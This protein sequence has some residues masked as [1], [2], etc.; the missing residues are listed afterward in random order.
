MLT[1]KS[2]TLCQLWLNVSDTRGRPAD[3]V[4]DSGTVV[5]ANTIR[6]WAQNLSMAKDSKISANGLGLAVGAAP[7]LGYSAGGS[8]GGSGGAGRC[9]LEA[10]LPGD[11]VPTL[12]CCPGS[13]YTLTN[14]SSLGAGWSSPDF[15]DESWSEAFGSGGFS[16]SSSTGGISGGRVRLQLTGNLNVDGYIEADGDVPSGD[17]AGSGSGGTVVIEA[18]RVAPGPE[19]LG[20]ISADGGRAMEDGG[21]PNAGMG[22]GGGGRVI[23]RYSELLAFPLVYSFITA[24]GGGF[25]SSLSTPVCWVG[26]AGTIFLQ[27]R[28]PTWVDG[29]P[30]YQ[31]IHIANNEWMGLSVTPLSLVWAPPEEMDFV[32]AFLVPS[33]L[34]VP[35]LADAASRTEIRDAA[36]GVDYLRI[37]GK[38]IVASEKLSLRTLFSTDFAYTTEQAMSRVGGSTGRGIPTQA[39]VGIV[40][41]AASLLPLA[42]EYSAADTA[43]AAGGRNDSDFTVPVFFP[44]LTIIAGS[45]EVSGQLSQLNS[46]GVPLLAAVGN[47]SLEGSIL[48]NSVFALSANGTI[49]MIAEASILSNSIS[50]DPPADVEAAK[51]A[52]MLALRSTGDIDVA[53]FV[54]IIV[55]VLHLHSE[56]SV[57]VE[58]TITV[59]STISREPCSGAI[60][61]KRPLCTSI[62]WSDASAPL[63]PLHNWTAVIGT[64]MRPMLGNSDPLVSISGVVTVGS[65][66]YAAGSGLLCGYTVNFDSN[67]GSSGASVRAIG[68]PMGTGWGA[69][70]DDRKPAFTGSGGSHG[71]PGGATNYSNSPLT[72]DSA[73]PPRAPG[74]GGG[75]STPDEKYGGDGGGLIVV[76]ANDAV[77][78]L[79][80]SSLDA[81]GGNGNMNGG[82]GGAAGAVVLRTEMLSG[83]GNIF[84]SGGQ[85]FRGSGGGGGGLF[86]INT[87]GVYERA[88]RAEPPLALHSIKAALERRAPMAE[89]C[90][91]AKSAALRDLLSTS[92]DTVFYNSS[93]HLALKGRENESDIDDMNALFIL[94]VLSVRSCDDA[95][96]TGGTERDQSTQAR[97]LG[98][99]QNTADPSS[100]FSG[101][102]DVSGG[103]GDGGG[104]PGGRG[105]IAAPLCRAG[106]VLV[107][108]R[109]SCHACA[110][111]TWRNASGPTTC[112]RCT[113]A[114]ALAEYEAP[115]DDVGDV[116]S[117][118]SYRCPQGLRPPGCLTP[119]EEL[120]ISFGGTSAFAGAI[121]ALLLVVGGGGVIIFRRRLKA[122]RAWAAASDAVFDK[123][124]GGAR[125]YGAAPTASA[126]FGDSQSRLFVASLEML[127]GRMKST[128]PSA[129]SDDFNFISYVGLSQSSQSFLWGQGKGGWTSVASPDGALAPAGLLSHAESLGRRK[130]AV[131]FLRTSCTLSSGDLPR[132]VRRIYF[133][134]SNSP[135]SSWTLPWEASSRIRRY[136]R[137]AAYARLAESLNLML[138]WPRWGWEEAVF[139]LLGVVLFPAAEPFLQ[140][141]RR[142][143][144][145]RLLAAVLAGEAAHAA[146]RGAHA[147]AL[148]DN[149]RVGISPD[150]SLAYLDVLTSSADVTPIPRS[151]S[152]VGRSGAPARVR[153]IAATSTTLPLALLLAGD[154]T[155][156]RPY[157]LDGNDALVRSV[158]AVP[159][160]SRFIDSDWIDFVSAVNAAARD[161]VAGG[162]AQTSGPLLALLTAV[163]AAGD[164]LLGGLKVEFVRFWPTSTSY[165][166]VGGTA[167]TEA[168]EKSTFRDRRDSVGSTGSQ[169]SLELDQIDGNGAGAHG[170]KASKSSAR[171]TGGGAISVKSS[172]ANAALESFGAGSDDDGESSTLAVNKA[173]LS[174]ARMKSLE[175]A[176]DAVTTRSQQWWSSVTSVLDDVV[177]SSDAKLGL[178]I[179]H[180]RGA[181]GVTDGDVAAKPTVKVARPLASTAS[182]PTQSS[183]SPDND[184]HP[185]FARSA[186]SHSR[187]FADFDDTGSTFQFSLGGGND[188]DS[189][190]QQFTPSASSSANKSGSALSPEKRATGASSAWGAGGASS[191]VIEVPPSPSIS[192][193]RKRTM[194][195][196][197]GSLVLSARV[198]GLKSGAF[199][200]LN[201]DYD[202]VLFFT[203]EEQN[204]LLTSIANALIMPLSIDIGGDDDVIGRRLDNALPLPGVLVERQTR[205]TLSRAR[206]FFSPLVAGITARALTAA[207]DDSVALHAEAFIERALRQG[208]FASA[209]K[210]VVDKAGS[211]RSSSSRSK[212]VAASGVTKNDAGDRRDLY[213]SESSSD[214][215]ALDA[216]STSL[217]CRNACAGDGR[218]KRPLHIVTGWALAFGGVPLRACCLPSR[219]R[220]WLDLGLRRSVFALL[221]SGCARSSG[222]FGTT[223]SLLSPLAA[224]ALHLFLIFAEAGVI[225]VMFASFWCLEPLAETA[226][227]ENGGGGGASP[228]DF[229]VD[230]ECSFSALFVFLATPPFLV[231]IT[232]FV[233]IYAVAMQSAFAFR[234]LA[235]FNAVTLL[236]AIA[237]ASAIYQY[238]LE[239]AH[240]AIILPFLLFLI[241]CFVALTIPVELAYIELARPVRGWRGLHEVRMVDSGRVFAPEAAAGNAGFGFKVDKN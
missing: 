35:R 69:G 190:S 166:E 60:P 187:L 106:Q 62:G 2:P 165:M 237:A 42:F 23:V 212:I 40:L 153:S 164:G 215:E 84:L 197:A 194:Q 78:L 176:G 209:T 228:A 111:G 127:A 36:T 113:N 181:G 10:A 138:A 169:S 180:A 33:Q 210:K 177:S 130:N 186:S 118:C 128:G 148:S 59:E 90:S 207:D 89:I 30:F 79:A 179:T 236:S 8:N 57:T 234:R 125:S 31:S 53:P 167:L 150:F 34:P 240:P 227:T 135:G 225:F 110:A 67:I 39:P 52:G 91:A 198:A 121:S 73:D 93:S 75:G 200:H 156:D 38:S 140:W 193:F 142:V 216:A 63:P 45:I 185:A 120:L 196:R 80:G 74:S 25:A 222:A 71:A 26:S 173:T 48:F 24:Q 226:A 83:A 12:T 82:G 97:G 55:P 51:Y 99:L 20:Y 65:A 199:H 11:G 168:D 172:A 114:P 50:L 66:S 221:R 231:L 174:Q 170:G 109:A 101:Y 6:I 68:C 182:P 17:G 18:N 13:E 203:G 95:D 158:P 232:P 159:G 149:L 58:G 238:Q 206:R 14:S 208:L 105:S 134:G 217:S 188:W 44:N 3:V 46:V 202:S 15:D 224:G 1:C 133:G 132:H 9:D 220:G 116:S 171:E 230:G 131:S 129:V 161:I 64:S 223:G 201:G 195:P 143:R 183:A 219:S 160:L 139:I 37:A 213:D 56:R 233:G 115:E 218:I 211:R 102:L 94:A 178:L 146:L 147:S 54:D 7:G 61:D 85:G 117:E 98:L 124:G 43:A 205:A 32:P 19:N 104:S 92:A 137:P 76:Q 5:A 119:S 103:A 100:G 162:I 27:Q 151:L 16:G 108:E 239:L 235:M 72:Y 241:K 86:S 112:E 123:S 157:F 144:A 28:P 41:S 87:F 229:F 163:N 175:A 22:G 136:F 155:W 141:R 88:M 47:F 126:A 189:T 70:A 107:V 77:N 191:V 122:A 81:S 96:V 214:E 192:G 49:S 204:S 4:L 21:D 184:S 152:S 154:G 145:V 29:D